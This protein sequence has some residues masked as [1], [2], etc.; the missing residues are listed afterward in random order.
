VVKKETIIIQTVADKPVDVITKKRVFFGL[1]KNDLEYITIDELR[2]KIHSQSH[3]SIL[4]FVLLIVSTLVC[5]LG[6]L[7]NSTAVVI[8]GML[9]APLTWPLARVGFGIARRNPLH[10]YRGIML[11]IASIIIGTLSAYLITAISPIKLINEEILARTSPT[12]MDLFIALAAGLVA[13]TAITQR[14]IAD[15]LAGVAIAVSLMPPLCTVGIT[16]GLRQ[17]TYAGGALLLFAINAACITLVTTIVISFNS[18]LRT[19]R[20]KIDLKATLFNLLLVVLL[21]IPLGVYLQKY[22]VQ[23]RSYNDVTKE[24]TT[25]VEQKDKFASFENIRVEQVD[26]MTVAVSADLLI[27]NYS[28]FTYQDNEKLISNIKNKIQKEVLLNL[29]IQTI[30]QPITKDQEDSDSKIKALGSQLAS[31][32]T[33]LNESYRISSVNVSQN[34]DENGWIISA[35]ILSDPELVPSLSKI[36]E[37]NKSF[38]ENSDESVELNLTFLPQLTLKSSDQTRSQ[39]IRKIVEDE[40]QKISGDAT[41]NTFSVNNTES[42]AISFTVTTSSSDS[43]TAESLAIIKV[44]LASVLGEPVSVNT[45]VIQAVDIN[46]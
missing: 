14:K 23:V 32:L 46:L 5:T 18:Y 19:K 6:L 37:L 29:R 25:F 4:Y 42:T 10:I 33:A 27:P 2:T 26:D 11:I 30:I 22:T 17:F 13:A 39:E 36:E 43:F 3:F 21:A 9:I 35:E 8:G 20:F 16:L 12:L 45:R 31:E 34:E 40:L 15:S 44:L 7:T 28:A 38:N 1:L 24:M 41:I